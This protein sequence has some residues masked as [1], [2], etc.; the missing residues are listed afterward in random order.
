[1]ILKNTYTLQHYIWRVAKAQEEEL[2]VGRTDCE[3]IC[4][5]VPLTPIYFKDQLYFKSL[6]DQIQHYDRYAQTELFTQCHLTSEE[7]QKTKKSTNN[8]AGLTQ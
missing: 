3:V 2:R 1:M 5:W 4:R 7:K 8:S 6:R